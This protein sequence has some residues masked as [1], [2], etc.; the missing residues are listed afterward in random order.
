MLQQFT[1]FIS[2][3]NLIRKIDPVVLAV[4]GGI[5][6]VVMT[7]LFDL[8]EFR[9]SV[10]HC[11]FKLRGSDSDHDEDFVR[12]LASKKGVKFHVRQFDIKNFARQEKISVQMAARSL[13]Q[14]WLSQLA[15]EFG[16]SCYATAHHRD[17]QIET[18]FINLLRGTGISGLH[19]ILP[20]QGKL[21]HPMLFA[22]RQEIEIFAKAKKLDYRTDSSNLK[23]DYKRNKIRHQLLP[24]LKSIQDNYDKI[25]SDNIERFRQAEEIYNQQINAIKNKLVMKTGELTIIPIKDVLSLE[26]MET[27]LFEI[28]QPYNFHFS[29]IEAIIHSFTT[30]P[31]KM[32][33]SPTHKLIRDRDNIVIYKS[34]PDLE[35]D[36]VFKVHRDNSDLQFPPG[37]RL[38][39]FDKTPEFQFTNDSNIAFLDAEI[40]PVNL[41]IRHWRKG[42]YFYPLGMNQRKLVSDFFTDSKLSI[43]QKEKVWLLC[44]GKDIIWIAGYRIDNRFKITEHTSKILMVELTNKGSL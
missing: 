4:S 12:S 9:Y 5:D 31:G 6:S 36:W 1:K 38:S 16:Y 26:P 14:Q 27:Y 28:L 43:A 11:N 21:I 24:V 23:T 7:E 10:A 34:E 22:G 30:Q 33:F 3:N 19:G 35:K 13:R 29:D 41:E 17:D 32:F 15:D 25:M 37:I 20:K 44:S 8:G 2:D 18:F 39:Q 40:I 42:D